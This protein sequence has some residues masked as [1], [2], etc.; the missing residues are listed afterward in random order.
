MLG[1]CEGKGGLHQ[2]CTFYLAQLTATMCGLIIVHYF[3]GT[4]VENALLLQLLC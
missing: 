2:G 4:F 1:L 3:Q